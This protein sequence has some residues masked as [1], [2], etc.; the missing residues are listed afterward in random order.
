MLIYTERVRRADEINDAIE[1]WGLVSTLEDVLAAF[2]RNDVIG[3]PVNNIAQVMSDPHVQ[4]RG[5]FTTVDDDVLGKVCVQDVVPRFRDNPGS[6]EWL[7]SHTVGADTR[8]VL[9]DFGFSQ[10]AIDAWNAGG[11]IAA[12]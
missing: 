6:V 1:Q 5:T 8:Q 9:A 7:G 2:R 10:G 4:A 3:G 12:P 11:V